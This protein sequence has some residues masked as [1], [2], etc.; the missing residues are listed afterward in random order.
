VAP[1]V[2]LLEARGWTVWWDTRI[3]AGEQWDEVIEREVDAASCVVAIWSVRS[4]G[5]RWVR[6][7]AGEGLERG[8][9]ARC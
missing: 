4:V 5:S 8:I 1:I 7:E 9:L 2:A 6:T 3:D